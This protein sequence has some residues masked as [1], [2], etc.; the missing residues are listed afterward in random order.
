MPARAGIVRKIAHARPPPAP[1]LGPAP[2][3]RTRPAIRKPARASLAFFLPTGQLNSQALH[4][5]A[6]SRLDVS[7]GNFQASVHGL[8]GVS[9]L[10]GK[11]D[12]LM[13]IRRGGDEGSA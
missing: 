3:A 1:H 6:D 2:G 11:Y 13:L 12:G 7:L 9:D 10:L 5:I 8:V 4:P